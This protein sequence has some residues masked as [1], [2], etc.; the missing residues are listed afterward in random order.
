MTIFSSQIYIWK[1]IKMLC[2]YWP[3][4][5]F[6]LHL[7]EI[8]PISFV[9]T[10]SKKTYLFSFI[11]CSHFNSFV[12]SYF[13]VIDIKQLVKSINNKLYMVSLCQVQYPIMKFAVPFLRMLVLCMLWRAQFLS[14][15][16]AVFCVHQ[17]LIL[18]L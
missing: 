15:F 6:F 18:P 2:V 16:Y 1:Q 17:I 11:I 10:I 4:F 7:K 14:D 12:K 3:L 9:L 5:E 8:N 13:L